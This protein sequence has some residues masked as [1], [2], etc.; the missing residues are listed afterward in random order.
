M[1]DANEDPSRPAPTPPAWPLVLL[2]GFLVPGAGHFLL[3]ERV[4]GVMIGATVLLTFALGVLIGGV[5][6]VEFPEPAAAGGPGMF[7][8]VL[9]QIVFVPQFFAGPVTL[10][11]ASVSRQLASDPNTSELISHARIY[12]IALLYTGVAGALNLLA[13]IDCTARASAGAPSRDRRRREPPASEGS[14]PAPSPAPA[15]GSSSDASA[16]TTGGTVTGGT[17]T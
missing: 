7:Q 5:R 10:V 2:A 9:G 13:L 17:S 15:S 3:R 12:D 14:T 6:V 11:S 1:S 16:P 4:R 8:R